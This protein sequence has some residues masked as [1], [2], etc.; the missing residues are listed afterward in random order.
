MPF[1]AVLGEAGLRPDIQKCHINLWVLPGLLRTHFYCDVGLKLRVPEGAEL[2][3]LRIL[4]PF[5]TQRGSLTDLSPLMR[6][7]DVLRL[8]FGERVEATSEG[9]LRYRD[10]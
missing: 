8:V 3:Q 5:G 10:E 6:Q 9:V 7:P 2:R 4:L 1:F